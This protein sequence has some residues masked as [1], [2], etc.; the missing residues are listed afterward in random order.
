M[1]GYVTNGTAT[2]GGFLG[3]LLNGN[4]RSGRVIP[5]L[6]ISPLLTRRLTHEFS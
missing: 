4:M 6:S 1:T 5:K 3:C 2:D